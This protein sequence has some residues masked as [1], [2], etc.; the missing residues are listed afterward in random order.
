M[1]SNHAL[2][3]G[4]MIGALSLTGCGNSGDGSAAA[5]T[6]PTTATLKLST[7]GTLPQGTSLAG[8]GISAVLPAGVTVRT[9]AD[10]TVASG[11]VTV[12]GVAAPGT[13]LQPV[14]TPASGTTPAKV[15]FVMVSNTPAGFGIGEFATVTCYIAAGSNPTAA[16]FT[17]ADFKPVDLNGT[18]VNG[19]TTSVATEIK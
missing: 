5:I 6:Q 10:G 4:L 17:L 11:V 15:A 1:N 2:L 13:V 19:L 8:I 12:T 14:I 18:P 16:D 7:A 9:G 3:V